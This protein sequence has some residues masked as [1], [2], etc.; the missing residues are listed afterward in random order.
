MSARRTTAPKGSKGPKWIYAQGFAGQVQVYG[1]D[2]RE[3]KSRC[4]VA[5]LILSL[6]LHLKNT[7]LI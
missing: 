3:G 5:E 7:G 4:E 1:A 2:E 6:K